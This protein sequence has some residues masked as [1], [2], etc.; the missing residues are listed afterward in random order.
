MDIY[1][2]KVAGSSV[3]NYQVWVFVGKIMRMRLSSGNQIH[4]NTTISRCV[5]G[6]FTFEIY[7]SLFDCIYQI[8][9]KVKS[10]SLFQKLS[11]MLKVFMNKNFHKSTIWILTQMDLPCKLKL[12]GLIWKN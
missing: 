11:Y 2:Y 8:V 1:I 7:N 12:L 3:C 10:F 4:T 6:P 9:L 5:T